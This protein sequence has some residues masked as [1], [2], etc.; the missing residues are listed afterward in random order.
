MFEYFQTATANVQVRL[1][2]SV[3]YAA[4]PRLPASCERIF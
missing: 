3:D 4:R 1:P 2:D